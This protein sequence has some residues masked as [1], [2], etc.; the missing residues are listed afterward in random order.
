MNINPKIQ[1][2]W[3][4]WKRPSDKTI[5]KLERQA[6]IKNV[7]AT[8]TDLQKRL[9]AAVAALGMVMSSHL[10][11]KTHLSPRAFFEVRDVLDAEKYTFIAE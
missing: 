10:E 7:K 5:S 2:A 6:E 8:V 4:R 3:L 11:D 9:D 1:S